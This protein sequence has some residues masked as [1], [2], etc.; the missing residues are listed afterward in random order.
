M[1]GQAMAP[2]MMHVVREAAARL[3][4]LAEGRI[5]PP[6]P[7]AATAG[8]EAVLADAVNRLID[9]QRVV[10]ASLVR[11]ERELRERIDELQGLNRLKDEFVGIAAHDLRSPLAV[12]ELYASFL[13]EDPRSC[14]TEK[15]RE[16]LNVIKTQSRFMLGLIND[17]LDVS[18]IEA[19]HLDLRKQ[20][21]DWLAFIRRNADLN[22]ALASRRGIRIDVETA[23]AQPLL[24]PFDPNRM[25]QVLNNLL[26]NAVRFSPQGGRIVVRVEL[27]D[28]LVCTNVADQGPG[29]PPE[30]RESLFKPFYRGSNQLPRGERSTGLGLTIA[31]R[32]VEAHGGRIGVESEVGK[33]SRFFFTLPAAVG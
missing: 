7:A 16:F 5:P 6:L 19:G 14:L 4:E 3:A 18:R 10:L 13:L 11:K 9:S 33:G 24:V 27:Q 21:G 20:T 12:I 23:V 30:D 8:G 1:Q 17:L 26:D 22:G 2:E 28:G 25:E 15:E 31:R 32:I 29:I